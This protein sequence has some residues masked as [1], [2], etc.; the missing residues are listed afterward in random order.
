M[1]WQR[2]KGEGGFSLIELLTVMAIMAVLIAMSTLY[3]NRMQKKSNI[4]KEVKTIYT[5]LMSVRL[6]AL[7]G[8]TPRVVTLSGTHFDIYSSGVITTTPISSIPLTYPVKM[9]GD[10]NRIDFDS[11]GMLNATPLAVCVDPTGTLGN[12]TGNIDSVAVLAAKSHMGKR[13][14]GEACA[15]GK[16][17]QK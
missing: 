6:E 11:S 12:N 2:G 4:E 8:K 16:I 15:P 9:T 7:Y 5:T 14:S 17:D 13:Q 1:S 10:V 3:Y